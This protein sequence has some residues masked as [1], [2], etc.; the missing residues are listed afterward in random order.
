M[1]AAEREWWNAFDLE[2]KIIKLFSF[3]L[4]TLLT[5]KLECFVYICNLVSKSVAYPSSWTQKVLTVSVCYAS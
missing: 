2:L 1:S 4:L 5:N 3:L